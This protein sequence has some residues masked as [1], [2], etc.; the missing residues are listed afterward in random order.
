MKHPYIGTGFLLA[1]LV[2][3]AGCADMDRQP[4]PAALQPPADEVLFLRLHAVGVQI[5]VCQASHDDPTRFEWVFKSPEA[6]LSYRLGKPVVNHYAGPTW[7]ATDGST[8]VGEVTAKDNGPD[9]TAIP[10]LLLHAK[11][12]SGQGRLSRTT[13][14]QRLNT[15]GGKAPAGGCGAALLG[16][17]VRTHY[18][19]DYLF[20]RARK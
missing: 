20:Y 17:E 14:I 4:I 16:G 15:L 9:S 11:S 6:Q 8:V 19:A 7:E 2:L 5:Y 1:T 13:S 3:L 18:T 12:T 10:W